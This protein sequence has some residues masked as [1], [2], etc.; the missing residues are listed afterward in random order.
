MV[1]LVCEICDRRVEH[2]QDVVKLEV[3][4]RNKGLSF[5]FTKRQD[6]K[7]GVAVAHLDCLN[8]HH[9]AGYP[10]R[11]AAVLAHRMD[12]SGDDEV[13]ESDE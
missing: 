3:G 7:T 8:V 13:Q 1:N 6:G 4:P 10:E 2:D 5:R 12:E 11:T 9:E